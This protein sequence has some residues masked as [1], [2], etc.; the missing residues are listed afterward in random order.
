M[1]DDQ[2]EVSRRLDQVIAA[3]AFQRAA[4]AD[5]DAA[6]AAASRDLGKARRLAAEADSHLGTAQRAMNGLR[7]LPYVP[8]SRRRDQ[9]G[10]AGRG[11]AAGEDGASS[12]G[13]AL[14]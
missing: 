4:S 9:P 11:D 1:T 14:P 12:P 7:Y 6:A 3:N 8:P 10:H 2:Q 13:P 5:A